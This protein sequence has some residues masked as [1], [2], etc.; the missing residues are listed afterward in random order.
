MIQGLSEAYRKARFTN[1]VDIRCFAVFFCATC[2]LRLLSLH[3]ELVQ[4]DEIHP[5]LLAEALTQKSI[6]I[7]SPHSSHEK[8]SVA[9]DQGPLLVHLY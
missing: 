3:L 7:F 6:A 2:V 4:I 5:S 1:P 8:D 9:Q